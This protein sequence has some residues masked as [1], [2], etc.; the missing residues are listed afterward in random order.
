[1]KQNLSTSDDNKSVF[2]WLEKLSVLFFICRLPSA[3][4]MEKQ[5]NK[6]ETIINFKSFEVYE[7]TC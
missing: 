2:V 4:F 6:Q 5:T 1:M 7:D 3:D